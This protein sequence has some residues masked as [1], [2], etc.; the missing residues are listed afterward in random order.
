MGS[1]NY[2]DVSF[3]TDTRSEIEEARFESQSI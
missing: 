2:Q 1:I 3:K